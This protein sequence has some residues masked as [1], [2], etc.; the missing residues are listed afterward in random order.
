MNL[1]RLPHMNV[2]EVAG[3]TRQEVS[4]WWDRMAADGAR[5]RPAGS[6]LE[7]RWQL[8]RFREA[9]PPRFFA[10]AAEEG[11]PALL[12]E[13]M[14]DLLRG[15]IVRAEQ[16]LDGHFDLLGYRGLSFGDPVD[17]RFDPISQRRS[18]LVHWSRLDPL[19]SASGG[20][21]KVVWELNRHQWLVELGQAYRMTGDERYGKAL[22]AYVTGWLEAN[23]VGAGINWASSLEVAFR[24]MAWCW[25][26]VLFR[27]SPAVTPELFARVSASIGDHAAHIERYLSTYFSPNTHLTGEALGLFYAGTL[28]PELSGASRWR[29]R[30]ARILV[31]ESKRQIQPDGVYFEQSTCYQRYTVEIG[32]HLLILCARNGVPVPAVLG[33]RLQAML[34]FLLAVRSPRGEAPAIGDSDGGWL[35]PLTRRAPSDLRGVFGTAAALFGRPDYAWAAGGVVPELIWLL[36]RTGLAAFESLSPAPPAAGPSRLFADGGYAVM[37]DGWGEDGHHLVFDVGPLGCPSNGGHGHADLLSIQCAAFGETFLVDPGTGTYADQAW[38]SFFRSSAAHSTVMVDG[39][40]QAVPGGPFAW[41]QRPRARLN[42]WLS[43]A[44]FDFADAEHDAY[45]RLPDPVRHRRRVLF[46][47][48]RY[49]VLVDDLEGTEEHRVELRFQFGPVDVTLEPRPWARA[50]SAGR[51]LLLRPFAGAPLQERFSQGREEPKEGWISPEYGQRHPAPMI[52]YSITTP[53]PLR[54][55]TLL[56]PSADPATPPPAVRPLLGERGGVTGLVFEA[57]D[58]TISI[59]PDR[60]WRHSSSSDRRS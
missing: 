29:E 36:G 60:M 55:V 23:P 17:W 14:P 11:T 35:L 37:R 41:R 44:S 28:F 8:D 52:V 20:D 25:A 26:L 40:S 12:A 7:S 49:W 58:E 59:G 9:V 13:R 45:G 42:R 47:K 33:E 22:A 34:D 5:R 50:T 19:D 38:R 2:T 18:A 56:L 10:G 43:T 3:R 4:K 51:A 57:T 15:V 48:P 31:E 54:I 27:R 6:A 24:L 46:V 1:R 53:L 30:G 21:S 32:L 39:H 16:A